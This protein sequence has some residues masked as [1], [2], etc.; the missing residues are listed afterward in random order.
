MSETTLFSHKAAH[1]FQIEASVVLWLCHSPC[2]PG[3]AGSIPGFSSPSDYKPRSRL[4]MTLAVGGT[5]NPNQSIIYSRTSHCLINSLLSHL[6]YNWGV[7]QG[8]WPRWRT[9]PTQ[10][11]L[12]SNRR[13][14]EAWNF[15]FKKKRNCTI[16]VAKT[17]ALISFEADLPLCFRICRLLVF[18]RGGSYI[19]GLVIA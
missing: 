9:G 17:K 10:T 18:S 8:S 1:I 11:G 2:K 12:H 4:Q 13:Q 3:V 15:I 19:P 7:E 6:E 5:L 16:R 14:L